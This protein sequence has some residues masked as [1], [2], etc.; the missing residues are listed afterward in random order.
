MASRN[1]FL[2]DAT[3]EDIDGKVDRILLNVR[4]SGDLVRL[5]DVRGVLKLDLRYYSKTNPSTVDH[6][7]HALKVGAKQVLKDPLLLVKA[8]TKFD[9]KALYVPETRKIYIDE[10]LHDIKKR[11]SEAHEIV[12]SVIPWHAGYALGDTNTTLSPACHERIEA[13]ANFGAGRLLFPRARFLEAARSISP[14]M[15]EL[16]NIARTF[17][18]SITST[19]WRYVEESQVAAFGLISKH[20]HSGEAANEIVEYFIRSRLFDLRFAHVSEVFLLEQVRMHCSRKTRGPLGQGEIIIGDLHGERHRFL[21]DIFS[22]GHKVLTLGNYI[23]TVPT[24]IS[25]G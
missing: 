22:N 21:V 7:L 9:L 25:V 4:G 13:E 5:E 10:G 1:Q 17:G 3:I 12:H 23:G 8:V 11:W 18:N 15:A 6:V 16:R 2:D 14:S 19:L 24:G 20:P